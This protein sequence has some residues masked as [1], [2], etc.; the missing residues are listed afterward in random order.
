MVATRFCNDLVSIF[1]GKSKKQDI[2]K[3]ISQITDTGI[4]KIL[5]N[6]LNE[7]LERIE[8]A[9]SAEGLEQMNENISL[10]NNGKQHKPVYK[11]RMTE[12]MGQ[13]FQVGLSGNKT[14]KF[15]EAAKGTNLFF[16]VYTNEEETRSFTTIPLN[17]VIERLKQHLSPVPEHNE[18]GEHLLFYLSPGDLVYVP[19][20]DEVVNTDAINPNRIYKF[21]S[22]TSNEAHLVPVQIAN[23]ILQTTELGSNNKSQ[24]AWSGE[25]IKEICI[26]LYVNRIGDIKLK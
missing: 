13:K 9:F 24:R 23:P 22:C 8:Y 11:V 17:I 6:Y 21:V 5:T 16:A 12:T 2:E 19:T 25:M 7:N 3:I 20:P 18:K 26:P 4:Q 14:A 15:V 10:Y 1:S